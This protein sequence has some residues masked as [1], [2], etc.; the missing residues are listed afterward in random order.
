[1]KSRFAAFILAFY[2]GALGINNFYVGKNSWGVIDCVLSVVFSWTVIVPC[3]IM[4]VNLVRGCQYL[5]CRTDEEFEQK[6]C[7]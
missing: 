1:M 6:Y 3:I 5:W 7:S 2:F 4:I